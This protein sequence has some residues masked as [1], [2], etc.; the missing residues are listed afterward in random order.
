MKGKSSKSSSADKIY[1]S[2][3]L[4]PPVALYHV[5]RF[6]RALSLFLPVTNQSL[7]ICISQFTV[8]LIGSEKRM[9]WSRRV[10][11]V[12][13]RLVVA[14]ARLIYTRTATKH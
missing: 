2:I 12:V 14:A 6:K 8:V 3:N 1:T 10:K 7:A 13:L 4:G 5:K 11:G 9:S